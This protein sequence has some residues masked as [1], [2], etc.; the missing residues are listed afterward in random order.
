[1]KFYLHPLSD[2]T[3]Y[4]RT[5]AFPNPLFA[6]VP[7]QENV[8]RRD[9]FAPRAEEKFG[10]SLSQ[11]WTSDRIILT[12]RLPSFLPLHDNLAQVDSL[13]R[14]TLSSS[15]IFLGSSWSQEHT[16][17]LPFVH[18]MLRGAPRPSNTV[19]STFPRLLSA[20]PCAQCLP[21]VASNPQCEPCNVSGFKLISFYR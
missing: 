7:V 11:D 5:L 1:M 13:A 17:G 9:S 15:C 2:Y 14:R 12:E 6:P 18:R 21:S 3:V 10:F 8:P 20:G 19:P 16:L 4:Q